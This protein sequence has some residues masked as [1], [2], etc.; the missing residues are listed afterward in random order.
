M[1]GIDT[2]CTKPDR[3]IL[4]ANGIGGSLALEPNGLAALR[5]IDAD[6]DVRAAPSDRAVLHV[7][8]Q[9]AGREVSA[10]QVF[11]RGS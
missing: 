8:R 10:P 1:A 6:D 7:D 2:A 3:L 11:R 4:G 9:Q 5:I